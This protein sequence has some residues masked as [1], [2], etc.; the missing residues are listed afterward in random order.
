[1]LNNFF[2]VG[3]TAF[4]LAST[5]IAPSAFITDT[6]QATPMTV[7]LK[8]TQGS[9]QTAAKPTQGNVQVKSI[10]GKQYLELDAN[11]AT[12][13]GPQVE[14]LLHRASVPES[15]DSSD[16]VS[17]GEIKSFQGAQWYEIPEG[18]NVNDFKSV[19]IWCRDFNVT[20]G[21]APIQG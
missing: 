18:I 3:L 14:V 5:A 11:F 8:A 13:N 9:F 2:L 21:Y 15:Y 12:G 6:A 10:D 7:A 16:Y 20:F 17:L 1:M 19:S 4:S